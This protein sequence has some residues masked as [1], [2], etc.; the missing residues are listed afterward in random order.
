[1]SLAATA[2]A[3]VGRGGEGATA[4]RVSGLADAAAAGE[5]VLAGGGN[6]VDAIVTAALVA[7]VVSI[8]NCGIGGYGGHAVVARPD[9]SVTAIDFNTA[10]PAA[11]RADMFALD[12]RGAV[13][14]RANIVGWLAAG[15]PGTLDGLQMALDRYGTRSFREC[16]QPAIRVARDGFVLPAPAAVLI[17]GSQAQIRKC[18]VS[19]RLL[20]PDAEPPAPGHVHRNPELARMLQ[21]LADRNS[22]ETFYRGDIAQV[23]ADAFRA[24]GGLVT[25]RDMA[26]YRAREVDPIRLKW[27][28]R[29]VVTAPL[30]AGGATVLQALATL[31]ALEWDRM[32]AASPVALHARLEALRLAWHDRLT[33]LGDPQKEEIPLARLLSRDYAAS[34][35]ELVRRALRDRRPAAAASD[36]RPADGTIHLSAVDARG[37]MAAL[38]LT[39]GGA[40]GAQ[41][42]VDGLGL[43]L[44]HGMS[45]LDP[46]PGMPNSPGPGK[47]P[48]NNMCPTVVLKDGVPVAALGAAGGRRIVS[49]VFE[50]L[51]H[52]VGRDLPLDDA[53]AAARLHTEGDLNVTLS[54]KA[55]E[56]ETAYLEASGYT[57][58]RGGGA[59]LNGVSRIGGP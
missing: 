31:R 14:G 13:K 12:D 22:V 16:V 55:S 8:H 19:S 23:I 49:S 28:G 20:M 4:G 5:A 2:A 43:I 46:R 26:A 59:N 17:R 45:R 58:R 38:T 3:G 52:L 6:A 21:T 48:L 15:V 36:G 34:Q 7:A 42:A 37:M 29:S 51:A 40:F 18:P 27:R 41:V 53:L 1:M 25:V 10:A 32:P 11:A 44:G 35:A 30:T 47:R 24:N 56:A 39:H 54:P 9:G 50:A 57:V 33:L